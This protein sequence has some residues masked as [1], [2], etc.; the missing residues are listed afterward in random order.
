ME[1][2]KNIEE[3]QSFITYIKEKNQG[4]I[5]NFYISN[6]RIAVLLKAECLFYT[7]YENTVF[8][9]MKINDYIKL[10]Y[11]S[12]NYSTLSNDLLNLDSL[13]FKN[14][15]LICD[16]MGKGE[17]LGEKEVFKKHGY[18]EYG[19]LI[20]FTKQMK[21]LESPLIMPENIKYAILD[22]YKDIVDIIH[23]QFNKYID[24]NFIGEEIKNY[25]SKKQAIKIVDDKGNL[26]GFFMFEFRGKKVYAIIAAVKEEYKNTFYGFNLFS[27]ATQIYD[28][29]KLWSG[30]VRDDN[31]Y[32]LE[33]YRKLK[34]IED[35]LKIF[36][37]YK[38]YGKIIENKIPLN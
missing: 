19:S 34:Y 20:H 31:Q 32:L 23:K 27:Y 6:E 5:T 26:A 24:I 13:D 35:G 37:Y 38:E 30:F 22:D 12:I 3:I 29:Y 25:I 15:V 33:Y 14:I 10:Y 18:K 4:Y 8:I 11:F 2:I 1:K 17:L 28:R 21:G 16:I 9:L 7:K 36:I